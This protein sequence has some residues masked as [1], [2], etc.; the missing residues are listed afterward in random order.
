MAGRYSK[1]GVDWT[2]L[3]QRWRSGES[4]V[5]LAREFGLSRQAI[6]KRAHRLGWTFAERAVLG[7][8][9]L[10]R[11]LSSDWASLARQT[12]SARL[13]EAPKS[14][15]DHQLAA[16]GT[17]TPERLAEVLRLVEQG[18]PEGLAAERAGMCRQSLAAW[19]RDD[20]DVHQLI[21]TAKAKWVAAKVETILQAAEE[22]DWRAAAW[23]LERSAASREFFSVQRKGQEGSAVIVTIPFSR[24][25]A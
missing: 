18:V 15:R 25:A 24:E 3:E 10:Q 7:Q 2:V 4:P 22:G 21:R 11:P 16:L 12:A 23:L 17:R 6:R 20:A 14:R 9:A 19:K 8:K 5:A 13:L 1:P